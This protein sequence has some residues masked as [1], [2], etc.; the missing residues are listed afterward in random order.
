MPHGRS[1]HDGYKL[2][3][4]AGLHRGLAL[5]R[6]VPDLAAQLF[7]QTLKF[8][9]LQLCSIYQ[10]TGELP[11][12]RADDRRCADR[13]HALDP[14]RPRFCGCCSRGRLL[15]R[16]TCEICCLVTSSTSARCLKIQVRVC[17]AVPVCWCKHK[18]SASA[19]SASFPASTLAHNLAH[20]VCLLLRAQLIKWQGCIWR[21]PAIQAC[22]AVV[23]WASWGRGTAMLWTCLCILAVDFRGFPVRFAKVPA[24][25]IGESAQQS[26]RLQQETAARP[27]LHVGSSLACK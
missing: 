6:H 11:I 22:F 25:G 4:G 18:L 10:R 5:Q 9:R 24:F 7:S 19:S 8:C 21:Q 2:G 17:L 1:Y 26:I 20:R 16:C 12:A 13:A 3:R 27:H 23:R 14:H 15:L